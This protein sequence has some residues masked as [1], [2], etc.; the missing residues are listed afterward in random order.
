[1]KL[2][3]QLMRKSMN[4]RNYHTHMRIRICIETNQ[5][6]G[7]CV[8]DQ[9]TATCYH[10]MGLVHSNKYKVCHSCHQ[11]RWGTTNSTHNIF[12][13]LTLILMKIYLMLGSHQ[14]PFY[15]LAWINS[16]NSITWDY[17]NKSTLILKHF[18]K[19]GKI[20][21]WFAQEKMAADFIENGTYELILKTLRMKT[22]ET[23]S[24]LKTGI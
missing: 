12:F 18:K 13:K 21:K 15:F 22:L 5:S 10:K 6:G 17:G 7:G 4:T 2:T 24:Y 3:W 23:W 9:Q 20:G 8:P 16:I 11:T 19:S 14:S 1:M